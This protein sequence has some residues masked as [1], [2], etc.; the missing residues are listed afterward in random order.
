MTLIELARKHD[1]RIRV[2]LFHMKYKMLNDG[3][4]TTEERFIEAIIQT[5]DHKV[6][7]DEH[8]IIVAKWLDNFS[9]G[10]GGRKKLK[11]LSLH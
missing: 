3:K 1:D 2:G 11:D 10:K 4:R 6:N 5:A 8:P 9:Q 7:L